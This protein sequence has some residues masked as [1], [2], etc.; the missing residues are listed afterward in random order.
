MLGHIKKKYHLF[1]AV[2][3]SLRREQKISACVHVHEWRTKHENPQPRIQ[4]KMEAPLRSSN[5]A[6]VR[7]RGAWSKFYFQQPEL[8]SPADSHLPSGSDAA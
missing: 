1:D 5:T 3:A 4:A 6:S 2:G 7:G 8:C